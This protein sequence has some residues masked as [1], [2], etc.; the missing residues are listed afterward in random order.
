MFALLLSASMVSCNQK[1]EAQPADAAADST[2]QVAEAPAQET[3]DLA[4]IVE[5][6]KAEGANYTEDQ[7]KEVIGQALLATKPQL[8]EMAEALKKLEAGDA[9]AAAELEKISDSEES[10]KLEKDMKALEEALAAFPLAKKI[11]EDEA[12]INEFKQKN[13]IPD[14]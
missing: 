4:A 14:M 11:S 9:S 5:K 6:I 3:P 1:Q 2:A 8:V 10:K 13:E 12:W 7:W